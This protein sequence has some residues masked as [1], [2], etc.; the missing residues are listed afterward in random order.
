MVADKINANKIYTEDDLYNEYL[1]KAQSP[2]EVDFKW[3]L[4]GRIKNGEFVRVGKKKYMVSRNKYVYSYNSD[5]AIRID[6][7][8]RQ[9]FQ[10]LDIVIWEST[11]LNEWMNL[12]ITQNIIFVETERVFMEFVFDKINEEIE[13]VHC[14]LNPS[15]DELYRYAKDNM[16]VV[17]PMVSKCPKNAKA[18][19]ITLEKLIVDLYTDKL[20]SKMFD[21]AAIDDTV[22]EILRTQI[23]NR[24]K[25]L[26]YAKRKKKEETL[27]S[28][29]ERI[30]DR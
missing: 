23:V 18:R 15:R 13:G 28:V 9:N 21:G 10:D 24:D 25:L 27:I 5:E 12:Q 7:M 19:N 29:L 22:S 8:L 3:Y 11:M 14:L 6:D 1:E 2:S 4:H 26:T 16:V 30:N 17:K 20:I